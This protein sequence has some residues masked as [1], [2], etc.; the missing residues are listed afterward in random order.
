MGG[1][2]GEVIPS[3]DAYKHKE[4]MAEVVVVLKSFMCNP[5]SKQ[6]KKKN[7]DDEDL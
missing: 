3:N 4:K 6:S 7:G 5:R 1:I 2:E